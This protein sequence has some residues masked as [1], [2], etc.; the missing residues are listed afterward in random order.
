VFDSMAERMG[1]TKEK[2]LADGATRHALGRVAHADECAAPIVFLAS[3]AASF[4]TGVNLPVDG[5]ALLGYW[6][7]RG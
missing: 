7:N 1:V 3:N 2:L 4:I 5:G 6:L